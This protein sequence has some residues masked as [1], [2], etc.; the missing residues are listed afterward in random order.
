MENPK[1]RGCL[2]PIAVAVFITLALSKTLLHLLTEVWWFDAVGAAEVFWTR[3]GWQLAIGSITFGVYALFLGLNYRLAISGQSNRSGRRSVDGRFRYQQLAAA[4]ELGLASDVPTGVHILAA[5]AIGSIALIA[6]W[7]SASAWETILKFFNA[8]PFNQTD[9]IFKLDLGFYLFQLP[10]YESIWNWAMMLCVLGLAISLLVYIWQGVMPETRSIQTVSLPPAIK[11]HLSLLSSAIALLVAIDFWFKRYRLLYGSH[12]V[13][14]G[15][16]YTDAHAQVWAY[17]VLS[18]MAVGVAILLLISIRRRGFGLIFQGV[19]LFALVAIVVSGV[20]PALQQKFI[21]EPNELAKEKPYI[22]HSINFTQQAYH[23]NDVQR[24]NY[25][26]VAKLDR[27]VLQENSATVS[28][29]RLWDARPLLSTYRQ[30]QEIRLYYHFGSVDIDRYQLNGAYQQVML[31]ARELSAEK[32]PVEAQTWVNQRLKFTHGYGLVMSPVNRSTSDG[33][34]ELYVQDIPPVATVDVKID[35]PEIYYGESTHNYIFTGTQADEFD[36]PLGDKNAVTRYQGKGGVPI[37]TIGHRLA[38]ALDLGSLELLLS[39]YFTPSSRIHY[40][41]TIQARVSHIAPFLELDSDPYLAVVKGRLQWIQDAYTTSDRYPYAEPIARNPAAQVLFK[42]PNTRSLLANNTN[43]IR[44]SVK[45]AID[46]YDGTVQLFAIDQTDPV[47]RT[48]RKIFPHL[49]TSPDRLPPDLKAHFRYPVDLFKLQSLMYLAY[50][51]TDPEVFY[52]REDLWQF[53]IQTYESNEQIML[54]YYTILQLPGEQQAE[55]VQIMPFTP[56]NKDNMIAWLAA[57]SNTHN[58]SKL[59]LYEFPK[60]QLVFGPRQIEAR[61]DQDP[62][63]SQQFTLWSQAGSKV[64]RGDLLVLPIHDALL[65]VEPVYLRAEQGAVPQLKRVIV[66]YDRQIVMAETLDR[67][68]A[69]VFDDR[70]PATPPST[71][72]APP[73]SSLVKSALDIYQKADAAA[74]QGNWADYGR[75]QQEL[76]QIL[77]RLD[78]RN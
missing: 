12:R 46:A 48:Y 26:A 68:L 59:L 11:T 60:K 53:P 21:V 25:G 7:T 8:T 1:S 33:L 57:R 75:Y 52:N 32:L 36:Y 77:Q 34:P 62:Q 30:L 45:V 15:A 49:F 66:A 65:Y 41:R 42:D 56:S 63:I 76:K 43:Y 18:L 47:L 14:V 31:S 70:Q 2:I 58:Y 40:D 61:I 16:G 9:P 6:A 73:Q 38:Y 71:V 54:P 4:D 74:R 22:A 10:C 39:N 29:I 55:F 67:A 44:N 69:A 51:M 78:R 5:I 24:Q 17:A 64:I 27:Q 23:L 3:L 37:P 35:R 72:A 20:Y 19:G 50:H 28:N 13:N